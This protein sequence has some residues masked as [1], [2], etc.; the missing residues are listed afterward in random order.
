MTDL[1]GITPSTNERA[2]RIMGRRDEDGPIGLVLF[3]PAELNYRCPRHPDAPVDSLHWS[4]YKSFVWCELCNLDY[5]SALCCTDLER[6]TEIFLQ[7]V[8][9]AI[10]RAVAR[11]E[12]TPF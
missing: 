3:F 10:D 4:E 5:P 6:T 2:E 11:V 12:T 7:S 1:T 8:Q 9:K